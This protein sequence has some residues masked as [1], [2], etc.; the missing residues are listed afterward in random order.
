MKGWGRKKQL[1][2]CLSTENMLVCRP[3]LTSSS[4]LQKHA[5]G[6][7]ELRHPRNNREGLMFLGQG[8]VCFMIAK[9]ISL[10]ASRQMRAR[11]R[12]SV[13]VD[14]QFLLCP[15]KRKGNAQWEKNW[16]ARV[17]HEVGP[18]GAWDGT[19][20]PVLLLGCLVVLPSPLAPGMEV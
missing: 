8:W 18:Q 9:L 7:E 10:K 4:R 6:S 13:P 17:R 1:K 3:S 20:L 16:G 5:R 14:S 2:R 19:V 12:S 15:G 11:S